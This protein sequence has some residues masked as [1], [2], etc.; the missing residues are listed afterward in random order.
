M[1]RLVGDAKE[2][3][4]S[5]RKFAY[6][7]TENSL[8]YATVEF[9][10]NDNFTRW[11]SEQVGTI[12]LLLALRSESTHFCRTAAY[13]QACALLLQKTD[14][15]NFREVCFEVVQLLVADTVCNG[16]CVYTRLMQA[17]SE[18]ENCVTNMT[19]SRSGLDLDIVY[20]SV[21]Y[22][23]MNFLAAHLQRVT[24]A[25][26]GDCHQ[27]GTALVEVQRR[28]Q[29]TFRTLCQNYSSSLRSVCAMANTRAITLAFLLQL[30]ELSSSLSVYDELAAAVKDERREHKKLDV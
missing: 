26:I 20:T 19:S 8:D 9:L 7:D 29:L 23:R 6:A 30:T 17:H 1:A 11:S 10:N 27:E 12:V 13:A 2:A 14:K 15:W 25:A 18:L 21:R 28:L 4:Q 16:S 22:A 24:T 3:L 5:L